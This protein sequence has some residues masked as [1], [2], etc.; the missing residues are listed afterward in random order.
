MSDS[1]ILRAENGLIFEPVG[2]FLTGTKTVLFSPFF[3]FFQAQSWA[4]Y[5]EKGKKCQKKAL[6]F[7]SG[8]PPNRLL[9]PVTFK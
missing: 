7:A 9:F 3:T 4:M 8:S 5:L 6:V 1:N 2:D